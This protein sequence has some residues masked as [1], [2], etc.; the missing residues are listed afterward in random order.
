MAI[1]LISS[2]PVNSGTAPNEPERADLIGADR[3]LRAPLEAEQEVGDRH[4]L[5]EPDRFEQ[6]REDDPGRG[7]DRDRGGEQQRRRDPALDAVA[8]AERRLDPAEPDRDAGAASAMA[9]TMK[10]TVPMPSSRRQRSAAARIASFGSLLGGSPAAKRRTSS[11]KKSSIA[12]DCRATSGGS[13]LA[14]IERSTRSPKSSQPS[15]RG[16][17]RAGA[18]QSH[19]PGVVTWLGVQRGEILPSLLLRGAAPAEVEGGR[20]PARTIRSRRG[21]ETGP[22]VGD[23]SGG[24][25]CSPPAPVRITWSTG[26]NFSACSRT[27]LGRLPATGS[28]PS[29]P[30]SHPRR[31]RPRW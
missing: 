11:K 31:T 20:R 2:V 4:A 22:L 26:V 17:R 21:H 10:A 3:G 19:V 1:R 25:A 28:G 7:Q 14:T 18:Q 8:G 27:C 6:H 29:R 5:E 9:P 23:A 13:R 12:G 16:Q 15:H 30:D 24:H